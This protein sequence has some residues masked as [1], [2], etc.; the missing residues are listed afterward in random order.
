MMDTRKL[1]PRVAA[2]REQKQTSADVLV[3]K[4]CPCSVLSPV[5]YHDYKLKW[6][7]TF[8]PARP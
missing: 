4:P 1:P 2:S 3:P 8:A 5:Q 7:F 6:S